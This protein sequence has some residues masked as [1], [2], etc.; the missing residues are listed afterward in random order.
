[1]P[2]GRHGAVDGAC[3]VPFTIAVRAPV[4]AGAG[5]EG[6]SEA[7]RG[8][9]ARG[10]RVASRTG[11]ELAPVDLSDDAALAWARD[12]VAGVDVVGG[13]GPVVPVDLDAALAVRRATSIE[14]VA[15]DATLTLPRARRPVPV[16]GR[17]NGCR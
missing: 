6:E 11:L 10:F 1:M 5:A 8:L 17:R 9:L 16:G 13:T 14:I 2:L 3:R 15:G 12:L 7:M 4:G